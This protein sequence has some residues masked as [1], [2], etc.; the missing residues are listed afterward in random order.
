MPLK[1][2]SLL[3][4]HQI[5]AV[6]SVIC[7]HPGV[8]AG[9]QHL[10]VVVDTTGTVADMGM[11]MVDMVDMGMGMGMARNLPAMGMTRN[12]DVTKF[13]ALRLVRRLD[14]TVAMITILLPLPQLHPMLPLIHLPHPKKG[15]VP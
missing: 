5:N 9:N 7:L 10:V 13:P 14:R 1:T 2:K 8:V 3:L 12:E 4:L 6:L 15:G 11:D